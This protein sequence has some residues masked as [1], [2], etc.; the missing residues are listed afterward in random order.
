M[1]EAFC[2]ILKKLAPIRQTRKAGNTADIKNE[3]SIILLKDDVLI[4]S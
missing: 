2:Q 4:D 3:F 1:Y